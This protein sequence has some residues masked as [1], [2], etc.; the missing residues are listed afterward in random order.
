MASC[1]C[2]VGV[3]ADDDMWV[4]DACKKRIVQYGGTQKKINMFEVTLH[5]NPPMAR[6]FAL[7]TVGRSGGKRIKVTFFLPF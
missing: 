4:I 5:E 7:E 6:G 3:R 2:A 1:N